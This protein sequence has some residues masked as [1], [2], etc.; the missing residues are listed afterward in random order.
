MRTSQCLFSSA[1]ALRRVFI[2]NAATAWDTQGQLQLQLVPATLELVQRPSNSLLCRPFTTSRVSQY[3]GRSPGPPAGSLKPAAPGPLRDF[4]IPFP[5]VQLRNTDGTLSQP[6]E[7]RAILKK[8]N[9]VRQSLVLLAFP[10]TDESS[11]GP[12]YPICRIVD[13]EEELAKAKE[14]LAKEKA[15]KGPKVVEKEL[16]I[17]WAIAP[18]DLRTRMNQLSKFLAKGYKVKVTMSHPRRKDKKRASLAEAKAVLKTL[19]ETV[20]EVAGAEEEKAREGA[21]GATLILRLHNPK[22]EKA[23]AGQGEKAQED[24]E[25]ET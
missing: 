3:R 20:S 25:T 8:L 23:A 11:K 10:R 7:K 2:N 21:V 16:E 9:P 15:Q 5:W 24:E 14:K 22:P 13:R 6:Q 19:E 4:D 17:N 18:H 12:E 1:A